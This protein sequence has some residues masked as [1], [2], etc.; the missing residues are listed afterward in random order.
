M[1]CGRAPRLRGPAGLLHEG[2]TDR[3]G[4]FGAGSAVEFPCKLA[5]REHIYLGEDVYIDAGAKIGAHEDVAGAAGAPRVTIGSGTSIGNG[6]V[7]SCCEEVAIRQRR[8]F[9]R[10]ISYGSWYCR[11]CTSPVVL[12]VLEAAD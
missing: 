8:N 7:I 2:E 4:A 9:E 11:A 5:G 12:F 1:G 6:L 3:F 10:A